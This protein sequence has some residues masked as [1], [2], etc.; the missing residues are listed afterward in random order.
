MLLYTLNL[1]KLIYVNLLKYKI[2]DNIY[3]FIFLLKLCELLKIVNVD[4]EM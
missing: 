1:I 3:I 2:F 4:G